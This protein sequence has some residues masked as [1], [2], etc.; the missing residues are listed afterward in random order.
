[1]A[2]ISVVPLVEAAGF[3]LGCIILRARWCDPEPA[4]KVLVLVA[5]VLTLTLLIALTPKSV[6]YDPNLNEPD[7]IHCLCD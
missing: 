7:E 2:V 6:L 5:A 1:M 4:S 3:T